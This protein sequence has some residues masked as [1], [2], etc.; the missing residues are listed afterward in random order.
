M[1]NLSAVL[2]RII[3]LAILTGYFY[4]CQTTGK[5]NVDKGDP[6]YAH[7]E[8]LASTDWLQK[9]L[10]DDNIR[11]VDCNVSFINPDSYKKG[12]IPGAVS[13]EVMY[14]LS[15]PK[16]RVPFLILPKGQFENL[17]GKLGIGN[18]TT[19]VV[20][21]AFG[22]PWAARLWWALLY[23]GHDNV[24]ILNG[25]LKK[26]ITEGRQIETHVSIPALKIFKAAPQASLIA[27][28]ED[29]KLAIKQD[30][31]YL[32]DALNVEH[33]VGTKPFHPSLAPA[34]HIPTAINIPG[35]SN[36]KKESGLFLSP[37]ELKKH[38]SRLKA[39]PQD[40]VI[41]YCGGG[42]YGAFD[43]FALYQLGYK[44]IS[45]YDGAWY[46]WISDKTRP[47]ETGE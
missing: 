37:V 27:D 5:L 46:E 2:W 1:K 33:H 35:P 26:W 34:G 15:D 39:I 20:Y 10:V 22:G 36:V 6:Q 16:G 28:I 8:A 24:K 41:T 47:I 42:Y 14:S 23:Y 19:V 30:N 17:M 11:I 44:R 32:V 9:H 25:G 45:L 13:L 43:L 29:V 40:K 31:I 3:F 12:H 21:D 7:P 18:D 4:G 38:W